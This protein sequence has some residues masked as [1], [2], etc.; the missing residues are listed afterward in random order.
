LV[1]PGDIIQNASGLCKL[2]RL[3]QKVFVIT[4]RGLLHRRVLYKYVLGGIGEYPNLKQNRLEIHSEDMMAKAFISYSSGDMRFVTRITNDLV[5]KSPIPIFFAPWDIAA[6]ESLVEKI[7]TALS[8]S[9]YFIPLLSRSFLASDWASTELRAATNMAIDKRITVLPVK[10]GECEIPP[11]LSHLKYVDF[12][13]IDYD[14][15]LNNLVEA[16]TPGKEYLA[17]IDRLKSYLSS[18]QLTSQELVAIGKEV[19]EAHWESRWDE[20]EAVQ[21]IGQQLTSRD[22]HHEGLEVYNAAI[23]KFPSFRAFRMLRAS[24]LRQLGDFEE[25]DQDYE[26]VLESD[27]KNVRAL[28]ARYWLSHDWAYG[29]SDSERR[30]ETLSRAREC[31]EKLDTIRSAK[32]TYLPGYIHVLAAGAVL[33]QE[34]SLA[35]K[36]RNLIEKKKTLH[37]CRDRDRAAVL[38]AFRILENHYEESGYP[39]IAE[40]LQMQREALED[41]WGRY[42]R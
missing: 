41:E 3:I 34:S 1:P 8:E 18:H 16:I 40:N 11:L 27:R 19:L 15:A 12:T 39:E 17:G 14:I 6:G 22:A 38:K 42:T 28:I 13:N 31:I 37:K 33:L 4:P 26:A 23:D 2:W 29:E 21:L 24:V 9:D 30:A 7:D 32:T 10:I 36:A 35:D 5:A 25:A 20:R